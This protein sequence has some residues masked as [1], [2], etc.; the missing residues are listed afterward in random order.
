MTSRKGKKLTGPLAK[1]RRR[2]QDRKC[3]YCRES[4]NGDES[5]DHFIPRTRGGRDA[6]TNLVIAHRRCNLDKGERLPTCAEFEKFREVTGHMPP[7]TQTAIRQMK[8]DQRLDDFDHRVN[9]P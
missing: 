1:L 5:P 3:F 7:R 8:I 9:T 2:Q 4:L 6:W